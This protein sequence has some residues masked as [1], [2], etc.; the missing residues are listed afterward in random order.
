MAPFNH[1]HPLT[2]SHDA[3][4]AAPAT[5]TPAI[6]ASRDGVATAGPAPVAEPPT[7]TLPPIPEDFVPVPA[8]DLRGYRPMHSEIAAASDAAAE[9]PRVQEWGATFGLGA[10]APDLL[11]TRLEL[12][13][14]WSAFRAQLMAFVVYVKSR[15]GVAWK[16]AFDVIE[17]MKLPFALA[18]KADPARLGSFRGLARL[19]SAQAQVSQRGAASRARRLAARGVRMGVPVDASA[20]NAASKGG[21]R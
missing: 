14:R 19:L 1:S 11:A 9:I 12:A 18:A 5:E 16:D 15:E 8:A 17:G 4:H 6:P 7:L 13:A 3:A 2:D 21:A 20:G 10:P